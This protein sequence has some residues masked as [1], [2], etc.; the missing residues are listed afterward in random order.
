MGD[1]REFWRTIDT[2]HRLSLV[3]NKILP[4]TILVTRETIYI[5]DFTPPLTN[6]KHQPLRFAGICKSGMTSLKD[7]AGHPFRGWKHFA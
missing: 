6:V 7:L 3:V 4:V 2:R 1:S 5:L